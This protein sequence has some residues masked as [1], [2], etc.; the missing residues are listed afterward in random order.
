MRQRAE[1]RALQEQAERALQLAERVRFFGVLIFVP[2]VSVMRLIGAKGW[3]EYIFPLAAYGFIAT[4]LFMLE[5]RHWKAR[6][7]P[8]FFLLD[9]AL[10]FEMQRLSMPASEFP[11]GVAGFSLG[12]FALLVS[13]SAS[14]M[15]RLSTI[16][17][18]T[19]A[20]LAEVVLMQQAGV[21]IGAMISGAFVLGLLAFAQSRVIMRLKR[22]VGG[23]ASTEVAWRH[24]HALVNELSEARGTI[25]RM[26]VEAQERNG[27]LVALQDDKEQLTSLLVHDL[28]A[29][30]AAMRANLEWAKGE[31]P[32]DFDAEVHDALGE[33]KQVTDRLAGMINDLLNVSRL[34]NGA[35]VLAREAQPVRALIE[36]LH[37]QLAAQGRSRH[38]TVEM[39]ADDVLLEADHPLLMRALEN[40][41]SN[42]LRYTP[43]GG[44][45]R[46]EALLKEG[47]LMLAVRN[48]G[49][50]IP[51]GVRA[52]L[53]DKYVQAGNT[54]DN[55][56][57]GWGL[58]LY[59]CRL[60]IDAHKGKIAVEDQE[61]WATSF[62]MK[63]P[64]VV[65]TRQ[66]A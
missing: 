7:G 59:F 24:E 15:H 38:I 14:T 16:A 34:E 57:A 19:L 46:V 33:A 62:V 54:Q 32:K 44:R 45:I 29:P 64:G 35:M 50:T 10:V 12:L 1:Q 5:R 36:Q 53:F 17:V 28:R 6:L 37:K 39:E 41:S 21:G 55:R 31:L 25:E 8:Y 60:C 49:A 43:S 65:E 42:A 2:L 23:M 30:L 66:A 58:G 40:I 56:R 48:D 18:A 61:G 52:T 9:V 27:K 11:A 63:I 22:I 20:I 51:D 3:G 47:Q 4:S 13:L 26:L